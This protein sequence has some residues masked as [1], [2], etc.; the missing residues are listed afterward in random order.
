MRGNF[1][2]W[3][4]IV[5]VVLA[6]GLALVVHRFA[7]RRLR[8]RRRKNHGPIAYKGKRPMVRF[9]VRPPKKD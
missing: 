6:L 7:E 9:S 3:Y 2:G 5:I 8:R 4:L 1:F